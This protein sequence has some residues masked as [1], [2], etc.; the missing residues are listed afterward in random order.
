ML[1][2]RHGGLNLKRW[3]NVFES[4][5]EYIQRSFACLFA[6]KIKGVVYDILGYTFLP[7]SIILFISFVTNMELYIGSGKIL[8]L[9]TL[10]LLGTVLPSFT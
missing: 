8:P 7:S 6:D 1:R 2:R 3:H 5:D 9:G 10:P 4:L